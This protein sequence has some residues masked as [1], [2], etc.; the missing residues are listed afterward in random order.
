MHYANY[1]NVYGAV[2][3]SL[4]RITVDKQTDSNNEILFEVPHVDPF[5]YGHIPASGDLD[6]WGC[7]IKGYTALWDGYSDYF[8]QV[9]KF[10]D[11]QYKDW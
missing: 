8:Y 4:K 11:F 10:T 9:F 7:K 2:K 3:N 6:L 5:D 1:D